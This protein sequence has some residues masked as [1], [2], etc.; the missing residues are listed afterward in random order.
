VHL[1]GDNKK[2]LKKMF[3]NLMRE[4]VGGENKVAIDSVRADSDGDEKPLQ[5]EVMSL[6]TLPQA[7]VPDKFHNYCPD[8]FDF[9]RRC[10]TEQQAE[11]IIAY[12]QKRGE[13]TAEKACQLRGQLKK[14]GVRSFG[15]KK[16]D[17]YYFKQ[18]G[19]C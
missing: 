13:L 2:S 19:L 17:N 8:V 18:S 7:K 9:L 5:E 10:D 11:E 1:E 15:P 14:D 12:L 6:K 16:E 3:P 4:L